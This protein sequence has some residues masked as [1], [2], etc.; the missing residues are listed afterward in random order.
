MKTTLQLI[1]A[2]LEKQALLR[3]TTGASK[4]VPDGES[5]EESQSALYENV[6]HSGRWGRMGA[7]LSV[8]VGCVLKCVL[9][10]LAALLG[11]VALWSSFLSCLFPVF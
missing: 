4:P 10:I 3:E 7:R 2:D 11:L 9:G 5:E 8:S 1:T 6:K